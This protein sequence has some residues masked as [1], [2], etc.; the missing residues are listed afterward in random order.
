MVVR[1]FARG[2]VDEHASGLATTTGIGGSWLE[3]MCVQ[4]VDLLCQMRPKKYLAQ[5]MSNL[6]NHQSL[7]LLLISIV[8]SRSGGGTA[9]P[10]T[11]GG[12]SKVGSN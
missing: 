1:Q 3:S 11:G 2:W 6:R 7:L 12:S 5:F 10:D 8:A 4:P 9:T